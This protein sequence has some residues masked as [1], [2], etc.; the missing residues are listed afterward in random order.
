MSQFFRI[1]GF[2][3]K[4]NWH[5]MPTGMQLMSVNVIIMHYFDSDNILM[6]QQRS[7]TLLKMACNHI[8]ILK[9][10]VTLILWEWFF[11]YPSGNVVMGMHG[12]WITFV[13]NP[14]IEIKEHVS[15]MCPSF[16]FGVL[17]CWIEHKVYLV[18][19]SFCLFLLLGQKFILI[20]GLWNLLIL[21]RSST[22][23]VRLVFYERRFCLS[24]Y[25]KW[26]SWLIDF[27][28]WPCLLTLSDLFV[29]WI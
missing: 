4:P 1:F 11:F 13:F 10:F 17:Q 24:K 22:K 7:C 20:G 16:E 27:L 19:Y 8:T 28:P 12:F 26:S 6:V 14:N 21:S 23:N 25:L 3:E 18:D 5:H 9:S 2:K 15:E 29:K